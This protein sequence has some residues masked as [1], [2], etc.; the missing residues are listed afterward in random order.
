[1]M[2]KYSKKLIASICFML[3]LLLTV[4]STIHA[5]EI[6]ST[7][8]DS[9]G[10]TYSYYGYDDGTAKLYAIA[11]Y[12]GADLNIPAN[13]DGYTVTQITFSVSGNFNSITIPES[14]TY[15]HDYAF[16]DTKINNLYYN[17][18]NVQA[19]GWSRAPFAGATIEN[20]VFGEN[21]KI[22]GSMFVNTKFTQDEIILETG[23][24]EKGAFTGSI[25]N[26]LI[27]TDKVTTLYNCAFEKTTVQSLQYNS[28]A[29]SP[30]ATS[31][32]G[33]FKGASLYEVTIGDNV[34]TLANGLFADATFYFTDF[35]LDVENIG[36]Y[37]FCKAWK[38][39]YP[40]NLT[41]TENVKSLGIYSFES[42]YFSN[43][44]LT[45]DVETSSSSTYANGPF[46]NAS[47]SNLT[48]GENVT[49]L[50]NSLFTQAKLLF[51]ELELDVESI[52]NFA[53]YK[54]W[55]SS[56]PVKLTLTGAVKSL[57][58]NCFEECYL[59][60]ILLTEDIETPNTTNYK[61]G[62]FYN[63]SISNLTLGEN[64][65]TLP[66]YF[67]SYAKLLFTE[68]ELDIENIGDFAFLKAW[69]SSYPVNLTLT[70]TVKHLGQ[71]SFNES[72]FNKVEILANIETSATGKANGPFCDA[73][74]SNLA[75]GESVTTIPNYFFSYTKFLF[76][77]F[78]LDVENIGTYA[79]F[80][81]WSSSYPVKMTL[82]ENVKHLGQ[83]CFGN[84]FFSELT[85]NA[86][87][88]T[89][90]TDRG[91]STFVDSTINKLTIGNNVNSIPNY[92]F[93]YSKITQDN[94]IIDVENI[95]AYAFYSNKSFNVANLTIGEKVKEIGT[96]AFYQAIIDE[97]NYNAVNA[98]VV[99][100]SNANGSPFNA[101]NIGA[102]QIGENVLV[103]PQN[104][105]Y[106][107]V[108]HT[109]SLVIPD[110]VKR[111]EEYTISAHF[112]SSAN[113]SIGTLVIGNGLEY[114]S[115][116]AFGKTAID[117]A[118]IKAVHATDEY[119]ELYL[120]SNYLPICANVEIHPN[121]DF[122]KFFTDSSDA[123]IIALC[124]DFDVIRGEEYYDAENSQYVT[125]IATTCKACAYETTSNVYENAYTVIFLDYDGTELKSLIV[126][127]G[128]SAIA[129]S[130]PSRTGYTFTGWNKDHSYVTSNLTII[131]EYEENLSSNP[132]DTPE[133]NP[134][135]TPEENPDKII[136]DGDGTA[137]VELLAIVESSFTITL[138]ASTSLAL[139][140]D[141]E[142]QNFG[143]YTNHVEAI[144]KG[145]IAADK[146]V[147]IIPTS[148]SVLL[149]NQV[150]G[151][152]TSL[153]IDDS[154]GITNY[155]A[156]A[157]AYTE[158]GS[159][160]NGK[161]ISQYYE[162]GVSYVFAELKASF[163]T[164]G[165]YF[166][167]FGVTFSLVER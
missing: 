100:A 120:M 87:T 165:T 147:E 13:I 157:D 68:F 41:F 144:V 109:E 19:V 4:P 132:E 60:S 7:Y 94:L 161:I 127:E 55:S 130:N 142:S 28:N 108:M 12:S 50:P 15:I 166:G 20:I 126:K 64:I 38:S 8:T 49:T 84:N 72:Y 153:I 113:V 21:V 58:Q 35:V 10:V 69:S 151:K 43:V 40:A 102:I 70:E 162:P 119:N 76:T 25:F 53:F 123:N 134:D 122:Y 146:K 81:T 56:Y 163:P 37:A 31:T 47:I 107:F 2:K 17:A 79:F 11:N 95:G 54:A 36:N 3:F 74:V 155:F 63:T 5:E 51:T 75:L 150:D 118:I 164:V 86:N 83:Y 148:N 26:S 115:P 16:K 138:P 18:L 104:M 92:M 141:K 116:N 45:A 149:T 88:E 77:D 33:I 61:T 22:P 167:N 110:N 125:P 98:K 154:E 71:K 131:A 85:L 137:T 96:Y 44:V 34:T 158:A 9:N 80:N 91:N 90:S 101:A 159:P 99:G 46:Y 121:S 82:T 78:E 124:D 136:I 27:I 103:L 133:E 93:C 30:D 73:Y 139:D 39:S 160:A 117:L 57:G 59:E 65:T 129:P 24:I 145:C 152:T 6:N 67:F 29:V 111:I 32:S 62:P 14:I 89:A 128:A 66:N 1:M 135:D 112:L 48:I 114:I 105:F 52:G 97:I 42:N 140:I 143:M 156:N 23:T 106:S